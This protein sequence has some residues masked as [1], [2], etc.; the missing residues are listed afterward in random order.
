MSHPC[1]FCDRK[2]FEERLIAEISGF[3]VIAS[4]GQITDGG[5]VLLFPV[6]HTP[7][8]GVL[9]EK[10]TSAMLT[11]AADI[12]EALTKEYSPEFWT[13]R[14]YRAT[15]FE[16]GIVGQTIQHG[17]LHFFP[18][19]LD[20]TARPRADFPAAEFVELECQG[21]LQDL[22]ARAPRP[23]LFWESVEGKVIQSTMCWN[24]PAPSQYFRTVVAEMLGRPER[25]NWRTMDPELDKRLWSETVRRLKPYFA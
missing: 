5:Y 6:E 16:H 17:H 10:Q 13:T 8:M 19:A 25:A 21:D 18:A 15:V 12:G 1:V 14:G 4:L 3:Y 24:P 7:C 2:Q 23:Y 11:I 22:Y 20:L 9:D